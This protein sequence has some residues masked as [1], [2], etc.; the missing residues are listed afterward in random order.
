MKIIIR[1]RET[2]TSAKMTLNEFPCSIGRA[3][4][5]HITLPLESVSAN[6]AVIEKRESVYLIRDLESRNGII[7]DGERMPS[8][9]LN[10][11]TIVSIGTVD[12]EVI[13]MTASH[14]EQTKSMMA[15][16]RTGSH[17]VRQSLLVLSV[18]P[19]IAVLKTYFL[20]VTAIEI[21]VGAVTFVVCAILFFSVFSAWI[22]AVFEQNSKFGKRF[23]RILWVNSVFFSVYSLTDF[24]ASYLAFN[25]DDPELWT[26][27]RTATAILFIGTFTAFY[28]KAVFL[29]DYRRGLGIAGTVA[30]SL[31]G[32]LLL[33]GITAF[34]ERSYLAGSITTPLRS[35][36]REN[37]SLADFDAK[38]KLSFEKIEKARVKAFEKAQTAEAESGK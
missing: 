9:V 4:G 26:L 5:S 20:G 13:E 27:I 2:G 3:P 10:P 19:F 16:A 37:R 18:I 29:K 11:H 32:L 22:A 15:P 1:Y 31:V 21:A 30:T 17:G 25:L 14:N 36:T 28:C 23:A 38:M 33:V 24:I 12:I 8:I 35:F 7:V 34:P 6:H